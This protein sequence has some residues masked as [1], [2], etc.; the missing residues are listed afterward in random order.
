MVKK[1]CTGRTVPPGMESPID[2]YFQANPSRSSDRYSNYR[3]WRRSAGSEPEWRGSS[4]QISPGTLRF[5]R[6]VLNTS[7]APQTVTVT[8]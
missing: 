8:Q 3:F 4:V 6:Q 5:T 7:S 2:F 1:D